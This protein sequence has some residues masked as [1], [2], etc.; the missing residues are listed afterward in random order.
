MSGCSGEKARAGMKQLETLAYELREQVVELIMAGKCGH[1]GGDM[2][3]MEILVAIY[4][5][6][7]VTPETADDPDRDRF[8]LSKGHCVE[9]L[10]AVLA[11]P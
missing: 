8:I 1:I 6:M 7:H 5:R 10:Y 4:D 3:V 2:S 11:A 9:A